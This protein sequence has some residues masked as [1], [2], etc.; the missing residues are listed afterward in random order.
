VLAGI[1]TT[2]IKRLFF[3]KVSK[4]LKKLG[5]EIKEKKSKKPKERLKKAR[6]SASGEKKK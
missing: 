1:K 4:E 6:K 2:F 3:H 5:I